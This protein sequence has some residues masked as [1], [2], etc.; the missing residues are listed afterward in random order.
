MNSP[1]IIA[2]SIESL[3]IFVVLA[4][5]SGLHS[6]WKKKHGG[7]TEEENGDSPLP[8]RR[9]PAQRPGGAPSPQSSPASNWEEE[10]R[11]ILQGEPAQ[12]SAPPPLRPPPVVVAAP[13]PMPAAP[14]PA[15]R[16]PA[17]PL[18]YLARSNIP[19]PL[20]GEEE[21]AGLAVKMPS[22]EQSAQA[23]LRRSSVESMATERL[24]QADK[25]VAEHT[26]STLRIRG[27]SPEA[28]RAVALLRER[29]SQRSAILASIILGPPKA[30]AEG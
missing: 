11:R 8:P 25:Q 16:Q 30:L 6:W 2:A 19:V 27:T 28:Q 15:V 20:E 5:L 3:I 22:L 14:H 13:P 9:P 29:S 21:E 24:Q 26:A 7:E 1:F 4:V 12:T 17:A 23:F 18:P 10:L